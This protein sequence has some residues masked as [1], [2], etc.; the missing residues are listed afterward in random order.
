MDIQQIQD[1]YKQNGSCKKEIENHYNTLHNTNNKSYIT[2]SAYENIIHDA[3]IAEEHFENNSARALEGMCVSLKD[4]LLVEG[5]KATG[6]SHF[7][8]DYIAP[9]TATVVQKLIDAGSIIISKDNCDM[10][11]HG[12]MNNNTHFSQF[13]NAVDPHYMAWWSSGGTAV[14]VAMW[15]ANFWIWSDTGWSIRQPAVFNGLVWF[16]PSYGAVSRYGLMSYA[17]SLDTVWPIAHHVKDINTIMNIIGGKDEKDMTSHDYQQLTTLDLESYDIK[18]KKIG[19]YEDFMNYEWLNSDIKNHITEIEELLTQHGA[20]IYKLPFFPPEVLVA[21]YYVIAMAETASNLSR[22]T[23]INYGNKLWASTFEDVAMKSREYGFSEETKKRI[24]IWNQILS[25]G[26][27][28]Y[29]Y[30][31]AQ[32]IRKAIVD[33]FEKDFKE[34]DLIL[35]PI[36]P[37]FAPLAD[38]TEFNNSTYLNDMYTVG[39]S[40]WKNPTIALPSLHLAGIQITG[41]Y[42][43]DQEVI[44]FWYAVEQLLAK[45]HHN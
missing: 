23:G 42:N 5:Q 12:S 41:A 40:L 6:W 1:I 26:E 37:D 43:N 20:I 36:S 28:S 35:S 3:T 27:A 44:K 39:F 2:L 30:Q 24:I 18:G 8:K 15:W 9:Y 19:I 13:R 4:L 25:T 33:K 45:Q 29:Y 21:T 10:F 31:K 34:I 22:L 11:G 17:S 38:H 32:D 7:L 14:A 16:K